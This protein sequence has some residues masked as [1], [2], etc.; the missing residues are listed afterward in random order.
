MV[1]ADKPSPVNEPRN[2]T[3]EETAMIVYQCGTIGNDFLCGMSLPSAP[4]QAFAIKSGE[5]IEVYESITST[6]YS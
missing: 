1:M 2:I 6:F 5:S 3:E 4:R